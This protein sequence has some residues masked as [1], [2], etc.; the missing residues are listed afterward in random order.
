MQWRLGMETLPTI[1]GLRLRRRIG[2][3]G[4]GTVYLA[5]D[6][7]TGEQV[8]VKRASTRFGS[9]AGE[10]RFG[11]ELDA[12]RQVHHRNV[13]RLRSSGEADGVRYGVFDY[14]AGVD[15]AHLGPI[16]W[17]AVAHVGWQLAGA[18]AAVHAAGMLHRDLKPSN[19]MI[20]RHGRVVLIDF[21][22]AKPIAD[23]SIEHGARVATDPTLTVPGTVIGTPRF[24]AP[25][26]ALGAP[27]S[28]QSDLY[29]LGLVLFGLLGSLELSPPA[30][31]EIVARCIAEDPEQ[32]PRSADEVVAAL[33]RLERR[34]ARPPRRP[35]AHHVDWSR[36]ACERETRALAA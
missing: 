34:P 7:Q 21:G 32:R 33:A 13:I 2:E 1:D 11:A 14:V 25:E 24:L 8:A 19:V 15:L 29:G 28:V 4:M 27:A 12:V 36:S 20:D 30:L 16:S 23:Q 31:A 17:Q 10:A 6:A 26:V 3:G 22:L 5:I 9:S 18:V 35:V